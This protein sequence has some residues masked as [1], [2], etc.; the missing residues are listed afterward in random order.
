MATEVT[1]LSE[2]L[3]GPVLT[4]ADP[5]YAA[6]RAEFNAMHDG[7]PALVASCSGTADVVDAVNFAREQGLAGRGARRRALGRR[8]CRRSTA[9]C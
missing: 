4:P 5:G 7:R 3:R 6:V 2:T 8:A 1:T 9:A